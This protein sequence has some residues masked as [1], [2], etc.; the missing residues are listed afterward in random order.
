MFRIFTVIAT[1]FVIGAATST[2]QAADCNFENAVD[3][4]IFRFAW[5]AA[6]GVDLGIVDFEV[7]KAPA[8]ILTGCL[9]LSADGMGLI[10][11]IP[12]VG[13]Y[14]GPMCPKPADEP[15]E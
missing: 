14:L 12:K 3:V 11:M 4:K 13:E 6:V 1:C 5:P 9:N 8:G 10:C 7:G 15:P 2:A